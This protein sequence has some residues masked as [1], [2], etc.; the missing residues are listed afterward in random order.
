[1][2]YKFE[3]YLPPQWV[4]TH[5][6]YCALIA[7]TLWITGCRKE[8]ENQ[9]P[10]K[11]N[12]QNTGWFTDI[13]KSAGIN[14]THESGA[15][16]KLLILEMM[17]SG[18]AMFDYDNDND[19]DIY[20]T[21][22]HQGIPDFT[23]TN[24]PPNRL[25][26]QEPDGKFVDVTIESGLGDKGF[27][28]GIAIG[29]IDNDGDQDVYLSNYGPDRLYR[30][31]GDG[32]FEDIT[33]F[34]GIKVD[35][36][37]CSAVFFDYDRD[38][39]LD[40]YIT[41]Y[42]NFNANIKCIDHTGRPDYCGPSSYIPAPDVLLHNDGHG[43]FED[44][45]K[46]SGISSVIAPGLGVV[47]DDF[48]D[49][50]WLDIYVANDQYA[51]SLW[52][53]NKDGTFRDEAMMMG[54][55]FNINGHIEAS[56]GIVAADFNQDGLP[57]LFMT[58]L[59]QETN[60]I[61]R[62]LGNGAGFIDISS[63]CGLGWSSAPFTGFGTVA[64]DVELDGDLDIAIANGR[65]RNTPPLP[66]TKL[67]PPWNMFAEPNLFYLNDGEGK[68]KPSS[69]SM[70]AF[71]KQREISRALCVGDIDLDGDLDMLITNTQG[72]A[73]L[74]RNDAPRKGN[75]LMVRAIDPRYHRDAIGARITVVYN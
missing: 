25:F 26:R 50:G 65:V 61:Y 47:C 59:S 34:A 33:S 55:A 31:N 53:N 36:L 75:W 23:S 39:F 63:E 74:Y 57:D 13:T 56:M 2:K 32:T 15:T 12:T 7:S 52:L 3:N 20:F 37:S 18:A 43:H 70:R 45:S 64:F 10:S 4:Y 29:D 73:R 6:C 41:N 48:N 51:N 60:T 46:S 9:T 30:N 44:V 68:F 16:G 66:E 40:L 27:G 49:D 54:A 72:P 62:N 19:L 21:T 1:M 38:G 24:A 8:T 22:G 71:T 28:M 11:S 58:H 35:G 14:F 67:P 69:D 5:L 42:V 17:S